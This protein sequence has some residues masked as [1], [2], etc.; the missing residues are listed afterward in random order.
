MIELTQISERPHKD[1]ALT[2]HFIGF[3]D[4]HIKPDL[5]LI[6]KIVDDVVEL[7]YLD[8]HSEIFG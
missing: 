5:V 8:S 1:H 7:H 4:C 6:Y 2:G 3:R